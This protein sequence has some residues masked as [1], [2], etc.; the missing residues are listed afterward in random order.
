MRKILLVLGLG[1]PV[2]PSFAH[3][4]L[5]V[6][7]SVGMGMSNAAQDFFTVDQNGRQIKPAA[8]F[9]YNAQV[10][11]GYRF[12][13]WR[14]ETG[15]Q[16]A[17]TGFTHK[18]LF[19]DDIPADA[20]E[21]TE[22]TRYYHLSVPL[23]V[24][25]TL[26]LSSRWSL[27]PRVAAMLGYNLGAATIADFPGRMKMNA[28]WTSEQFKKEKQSV[29]FWGSVSLLAEYGLSHRV[30]LF[31]GPGMQYMLSNFLKVPAGAPYKATERPYFINMDLGARINL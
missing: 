29:S 7:P 27:S 13:R 1:M 11:I 25:Y 4:G 31:A 21:G 10:G 17:I 28:P 19:F 23:C 3:R 9:C 20:A 26:P 15:L 5:Y 12:G 16:Y 30:S 8:V 6:A 2:L 22:Q 24:G 14:L 18:A